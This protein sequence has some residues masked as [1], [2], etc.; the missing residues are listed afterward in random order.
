VENK[1]E[2]SICIVSKNR[3]I[4]LQKTLSILASC[5]DITK[6]E[7]LVFLDGCTDNSSKLAR[8]FPW[9]KWT[10]IAKS[11]GASKAR[12]LL[13]IKASGKYII[14]FDDDAHPIQPDFIEKC[15]AIFQR[16][17]KVGIIAF[18]EITGVY[19]KEDLTKQANQSL[20]EYP[21]SEFVG[22]GFAVR[23]DVYN[24]TR[25]FPEWIDIYGEENCLSIEVLS[26]NYTILYTNAIA[27][28]HRINVQN[29]LEQGKNYF[30]FGKQLKNSTFYYFVYYP[31][32]IK[33]IGK[34]YY[35][36]LN[37]YALTDF[38]YLKIFFKTFFLCIFKLPLLMKYRE[39]VDLDVI[40]LK[41]SLPFPG[42]K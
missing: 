24:A 13:F 10:T 14:G 15:I 11:V 32:P 5:I 39:P 23:S 20:I 35:H 2:I 12:S 33:K 25:G 40:K 9:V 36:N 16:H 3:K 17:P 37:K 19:N 26:K 8:E 18:K 34:L 29:R 27:V 41:E 30:R 42:R 38:K 28:N 31:N 4:E 22:C 6:H 21:C 7:V 1:M